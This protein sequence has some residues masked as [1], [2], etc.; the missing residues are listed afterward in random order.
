[1]NLVPPWKPSL[2]AL[3]SDC[4]FGETLVVASW[5]GQKI[6][7]SNLW[8]GPIAE[9]ADD[10]FRARNLLYQIVVSALWRSRR[11]SR[12][13]MDGHGNTDGKLGDAR[14]HD[15]IHEREGR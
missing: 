7:A 13:E 10:P 11:Y 6:P 4:E 14:T 3:H 15:A 12:L 8:A 9:D 5:M 2:G 1:M